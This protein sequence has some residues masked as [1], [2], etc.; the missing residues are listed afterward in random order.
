MRK[1]VS[2][3]AGVAFAAILTH[4][5]VFCAMNLSQDLPVLSYRGF[6]QHALFRIDSL[7]S[8]VHGWPSETECVAAVR[9]ARPADPARLDVANEICRMTHI[10]EFGRF[11]ARFV[12]LI[13][14]LIGFMVF[15]AI[16]GRRL[17]WRVA[18]GMAIAAGYMA[19]RDFV[20]GL[21]HETLWLEVALAAAITVL[22]AWSAGALK[23]GPVT[24]AVPA[25]A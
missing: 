9:Q 3:A 8:R 10:D 20:P 24:P 21:G 1:P 7:W 11:Y 6:F 13:C 14:P 16:C 19:V 12:H 4:G 23:T 15:A 5:M 2:I 25:T 18:R 17:G 22:M